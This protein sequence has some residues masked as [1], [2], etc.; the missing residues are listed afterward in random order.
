MQTNDNKPLIGFIGQGFI[1]SAYSNNF[2]NRGYT[3]VRY[4]I[5]EKYRANRDQI[6]NCDIVFVAVPT[7]TTL[8]GFDASILEDALQATG[9]QI[10]VIKSTVLPNTPRDL[11]TKFPGK[12]ILHSP[13]FLTEDT[14]QH[15]AD[16][17][18]HNIVGYVSGFDEERARNA[19]KLALSVL[20]KAAYE[21]ITTAET[22]SL[23]K[24]GSNCFFYSKVLLMNTLYDLTD[25]HGA[26]WDEVAGA[27]GNDPRVGKSHLVVVHKGGRGAGGNC[28][29]KDFAAYR[30][31]YQKSCQHLPHGETAIKYLEQI[32]KFNRELLARSNKS[33]QIVRAVYG[34]NQ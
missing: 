25:S 8:S 31:M 9:E 2:E 7:P 20:P 5:T 11:Q 34:D 21:L 4:D 27:I 14:A 24:Y 12:I 3:V 16:H 23:I 32:E 28:L 29:F 26:N 15:D 1:G 19:A 10:V 17:P 33:Q 13:E 6:K 22:A 30:E 18:L